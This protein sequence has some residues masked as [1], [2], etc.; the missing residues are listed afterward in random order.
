[1]SD[2][3]ILSTRIVQEL[4]RVGAALPKDHPDRKALATRIFEL[5]DG[6]LPTKA[7]IEAYTPLPSASR[8]PAEHRAQAVARIADYLWQTLVQEVEAGI[9]VQDL[10]TLVSN[11]QDTL[12]SDDRNTVGQAGPLNT[13]EVLGIVQDVMHAV[14]GLA[15]PWSNRESLLAQYHHTDLGNAERFLRRYHQDLRYCH[16]FRTWFI[17]DGHVWRGDLVQQIQVMANETIRGIYAESAGLLN[18]QERIALSKHATKS[19]SAD[20]K[21]AMVLS[22]GPLVSVKPGIWDAREDLFCCQNGT[23]DLVRHIF[24]AHRRSDLLTRQAGVEFNPTAECPTWLAH[25]DLVFDQ[26]QDFITH[27]RRFCGYTLLAEN[28]AQVMFIAYGTG[29][30]GKSVTLGTLSYIWGDYAL[31]LSA[32]SLMVRRSEGPRTDL[33]R[34]PGARLVTASEGD[35]GSRLSEAWVK[36]LTGEDQITVRRLYQEEFQFVPKGKIWFGT[37]HLP[38]VRGSDL[39]I[40]RRLWP[41]PFTVTIPPDKRDSSIKDRLR[42]EASGILNWCL[43]GLRDYQ[44][45]GYLEKPRRVQE[46]A[47]A[48]RAD[49]DLI[50][51]YLEERCVLDSGGKEPRKS[52]FADYKAWCEWSGNETLSQK[53]FA[54]RL[55][56]HGVQDGGVSGHQNAR[57]WKGI[58]LKTQ[59][60]LSPFCRGEKQ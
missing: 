24:R 22:A 48:Y 15:T 19:E 38:T 56:D 47:E 36:Q 58:R 37:N 33:A 52:I 57:Y 17:W 44:E 4:Q 59:S 30:N 53:A 12:S 40:W 20:R 51:S 49:Q 6:S 34:L 32:E 42:T 13:D 26:D 14:E 60:E 25:L 28:P 1:M 39:A 5:L 46:A 50:G 23:Y 11:Y 27:F 45:R 29:Q 43:A 3:D 21:A 55:K 18:D 35:A 10:I 16:A 54:N 31:N 9:S 41:I 2:L 7:E 8:T